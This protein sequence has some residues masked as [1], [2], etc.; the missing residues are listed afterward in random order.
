[1]KNTTLKIGVVL[2]AVVAMAGCIGGSN[3]PRNTSNRTTSNTNSEVDPD[4]AAKVYGLNEAAAAGDITHTITFVE[5]LDTIPKSY[6]LPEWEIIAE[7]LPADKDFQWI[8]V[9]GT[10]KNGSKQTQTVNS[11]S[12]Y[13]VDADG[14]QFDVSTDTTIYIP[15]DT[16][17][18]YLTLQPTQSVEWEG[19]FMIP[20]AAEDVM[21]V[22][23]DLSFVPEDVVKI[24]LGL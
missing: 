9:K 19:Y 11:T 23:N 14:N 18:I 22:A 10:V 8:H 4:A 6:T 16:S 17:P 1:M 5:A 15:D 7:D 12:V 13:L 3:A 2:L 21:L 20:T 24:D